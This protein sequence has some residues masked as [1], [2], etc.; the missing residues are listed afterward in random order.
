MAPK[1]EKHFDSQPHKSESRGWVGEQNA[2]DVGV[3]GKLTL[4]CRQFSM[5]DNIPITKLPIPTG[6][7]E[8]I[9]KRLLFL[10]RCGHFLKFLWMTRER[11]GCKEER[12]SFAIKD[13]S[14]PDGRI[15]SIMNEVAALSAIVVGVKIPS[16]NCET[17]NDKYPFDRTNP[18]PAFFAIAW[19]H[20]HTSEISFGLRG[21]KG[22]H[23][24][25][26]M[27]LGLVVWKEL[28]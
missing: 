26:W 2:D 25:P 4:P 24:Q 21:L 28:P 7:E 23:R 3:S 13:N 10:V 5:I 14:M 15:T 16:K 17:K 8:P 18:E 20:N 1:A 11:S 6:S 12:A 9:I 27:G 19:V 22:R